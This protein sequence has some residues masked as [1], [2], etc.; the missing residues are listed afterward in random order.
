MRHIAAQTR[1]ARSV[2]GVDFADDALAIGEFADK[3]MT[4]HAVKIRITSRDFEIGAANPRAA[5]AYPHFVRA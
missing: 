3:F 4:E 2:V 5:H 1:R